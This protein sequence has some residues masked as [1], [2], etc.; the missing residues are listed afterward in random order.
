M[1]S[2]IGMLKIVGDLTGVKAD[3]SVSFAARTNVALKIN[4]FCLPLNDIVISITFLYLRLKTITHSLSLRISPKLS[5]L[6]SR[7]IALLGGIL[8]DKNRTGSSFE[9]SEDIPILS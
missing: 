6:K 3:S 4:V 5:S 8:A 1:V 2:H 7:I 9:L